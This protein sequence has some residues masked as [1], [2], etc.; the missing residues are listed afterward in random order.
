MAQEHPGDIIVHYTGQ[1][2][3]AEWKDRDVLPDDFLNPI[4]DCLALRGVGLHALLIEQVVNLMVDVGAVVHEG[5]VSRRDGHYW[6]SP[7]QIRT[8]PIKASGSY[9]GYLAA[10]RVSLRL[11]A[12]G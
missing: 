2:V 9:R 5:N 10:S 3:G 11:S 8:G 12:R 6:P 1:A 7:A 4:V